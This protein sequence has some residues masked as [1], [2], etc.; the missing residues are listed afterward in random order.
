MGALHEGHFAL[1]EKAM[2]FSDSVLVSVFVNPL[3]FEDPTD[4]EKYPRSPE[5]DIEF[6][7]RAGATAIW[8]PK[9]KEIFPEDVEIISAEHLGDLYEGASRPSH[10][11]GMLTVV[12]RLFELVKPSW[13]VFGEK[14]YQQLFLVKK[15]VAER[16]L[17][18]SI[19]AVETV[20]DSDGLAI[21]SRNARLSE[22]DRSIAL[23]ISQALQAAVRERNLSDA[24]NS[25]IRILE[26][27]PRFRLDYAVVIDE[28]TFLE[29]VENT[30]HR[31][32]LVAG[33]VNGVRLIDNMPMEKS[34]EIAVE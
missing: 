2:T 29:A 11:S 34:A 23:V 25:L 8:F 14:D 4:L 32:A 19:I 26:S 30:L 3:Q 5:K 22:E 28:E 10:F 6:A 27:E 13:A 20:R 1:I 7:R 31:R 33:W 18:I 24:R 16:K 9:A 12:S 15:M 21:S 17:P